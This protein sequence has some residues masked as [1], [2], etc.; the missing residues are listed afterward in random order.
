M[1]SFINKIIQITK[2]QTD[3]LKLIFRNLKN[4]FPQ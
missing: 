4:I 2:I 3:L 1:V